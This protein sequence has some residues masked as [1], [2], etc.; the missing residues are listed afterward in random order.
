MP[1]RSRPRPTPSA[2]TSRRRRLARRDARRPRGAR[3]GSSASPR[4][5]PRPAPSSSSSSSG[6]SSD[7][8]RDLGHRAR[9]PPTAPSLDMSTEI[10]DAWPAP[11]APRRAARSSG[12]VVAADSGR[13]RD[14]PRRV[15]A[16]RPRGRRCRPPPTTPRRPSRP[17]T[18]PRSCEREAPAY[19]LLGATP[20]GRDVAGRAR[21]PCSAGASWPTRPARR[22]RTAV[23]GRDERLRRLAAH[24]AARSPADHGIVTVRPSAVDRRARAG[25]GSGRTRDRRRRRALPRVSVL[26][27]VAEAGRQASIEEAR[28][29]W[30]AAVASAVP[31]ASA[32]WRSSPTRSAARSG[33]PGRPSTPAGS[34]TPTRSARP[35]RPSSRSCTSRSA[36]R[37]RSSTRSACRRPR[38]SWRSTATPTRRSRSSPTCTSSATCSRSV[39]ALLAEL[40]RAGR[41][42]PART[43]D[44]MPEVALIL[45]P[46]ALGVALAAATWIVLSRTGHRRRREPRRLRRPGGDRRA[47]PA[48]ADTSL[49]AI[50]APIDRVRRGQGR[51]VASWPDP[52]PLAQAEVAALTADARA[53]QAPAA[54]RPSATTSSRELERAARALDMVEHGRASCWPR[55]SGAASSRPR[56][57]S[58]A[59]TSTSSTLAR[60]SRGD[61]GGP[62]PGARRPRRGATPRPTPCRAG[63]T[64]TPRLRSPDDTLHVVVGSGAHHKR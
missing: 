6:G 28:S 51:A 42:G 39:P 52:L 11:S 16:A 53:I 47:S 23:R 40:R 61:A 12:V 22:G 44:A 32:W 63:A 38:R 36:S 17:S 25:A 59:A 15:P 19:L 30:P 54:W 2:A 48:R 21:A 62:P 14:G 45:L 4:R 55:A 41:L 3:R 9:R 43:A 8:R 1:G 60:R 64:P 33:R 37:A 26:D 24:D 56:P 27:R 10:G 18:S 34:A 49:S 58:S 13:C 46:V 7:G 50:A 20:D 29:S 57:P 35:A 5:P 31:T